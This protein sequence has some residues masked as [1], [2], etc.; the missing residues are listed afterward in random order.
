ML[1]QDSLNN[2]EESFRLSL[3]TILGV[4]PLSDK[5]VFFLVKVNIQ[6]F[7]FTSFSNR[8]L[9]GEPSASQVRLTHEAEANEQNSEFQPTRE[10]ALFK[11]RTASPS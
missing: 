8:V 6:K 5:P 1:T 2:K 4:T 3:F 7:K 9:L 11:G 10:R